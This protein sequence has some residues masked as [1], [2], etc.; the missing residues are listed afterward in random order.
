MAGLTAANTAPTPTAFFT[1]IPACR[2]D[3]A[4]YITKE[5]LMVQSNTDTNTISSGMISVASLFPMFPSQLQL[6]P[7]NT[8]ILKANAPNAQFS[9]LLAVSFSLFGLSS[10]EVS[11]TLRD[12]DDEWR[13]ITAPRQS[14]TK[15]RRCLIYVGWLKFS[16]RP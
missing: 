5:K 10:I 13:T 4:N 9:T 14:C 15:I 16:D 7:S 1:A 11:P 6:V 12:G 8:D 2:R 3:L